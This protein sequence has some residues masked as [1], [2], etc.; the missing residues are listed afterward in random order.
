MTVRDP[1]IRK[2]LL[3]CLGPLLLSENWKLAG[4]AVVMAEFLSRR[5][6]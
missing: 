3:A 5:A 6:I 1:D 2:S 4:G